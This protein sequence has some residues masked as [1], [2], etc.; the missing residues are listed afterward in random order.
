MIETIVVVVLSAFIEGSG[1]ILSD[2]WVVFL[3]SS[4]LSLFVLLSDHNIKFLGSPSD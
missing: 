2:R 4:E 1:V 3:E